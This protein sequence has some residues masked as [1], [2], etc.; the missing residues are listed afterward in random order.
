MGLGVLEDTKLDPEQASYVNSIH[1]SGRVLL[2]LIDD[3]LDI[4]KIEAGKI[5]LDAAPFRM[6]EIV[7]EIRDLFH[8]QAEDKGIELAILLE[9]EADCSVVGDPGRI[10][11]VPSGA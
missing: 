10:R 1:R 6:N 7:G 5:R 8:R 11:Q 4:S 3:V 9:P 2:A